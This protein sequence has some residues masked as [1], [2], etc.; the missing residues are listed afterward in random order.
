MPL[1]AAAGRA[2]SMTAQARSSSRAAEEEEVE[3]LAKP[4]APELA[5]TA[6]HLPEQLGRPSSTTTAA[7]PK[8]VRAGLVESAEREG[9]DFATHAT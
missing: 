5:V 2:H 9:V 6:E 1:E 4:A 7:L 3:E 8:A